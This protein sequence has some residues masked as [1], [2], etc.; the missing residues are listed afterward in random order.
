MQRLKSFVTRVVSH[1]NRNVI[2]DVKKDVVQTKAPDGVQWPQTSF[3][4]LDAH[5]PQSSL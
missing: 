4:R 3:C 2:E 5:R 1:R